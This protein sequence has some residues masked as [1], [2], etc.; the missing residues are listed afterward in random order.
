MV[1]TKG[2]P[3]CVCQDGDCQTCYPVII[4]ISYQPSRCLPFV[5]RD[6]RTGA[7]QPFKTQED[8]WHYAKS[9]GLGYVNE[10]TA[11]IEG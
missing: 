9:N 6:S 1:A 3:G 5:F 2:L 8:A 7:I 10:V 4:C 11:P